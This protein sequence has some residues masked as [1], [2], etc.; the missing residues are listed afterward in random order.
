M[1]VPSP[2]SWPRW[3]APARWYAPSA[4]PSA[5]FERHHHTHDW[6]YVQTE[7]KRQDRSARCAE[8]HCLRDRTR[9]L[10]GLIRPVSAPCATAD[11]D[12]GRK[13]FSSASIH[14]IF[15]SIGTPLEECRSAWQLQSLLITCSSE[16]IPCGQQ[17]VSFHNC[18]GNECRIGSSRRNL[19]FRRSLKST[20]CFRQGAR[21]HEAISSELRIF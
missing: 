12:Q 17:T 5:D 14:A 21:V 6:M 8:K 18:C 10:R 2:S 19:I 11:V 7:R 16:G 15:M 4:M 13:C 3:P 1:L 20:S 9:R